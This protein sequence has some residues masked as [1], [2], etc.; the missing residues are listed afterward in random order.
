M[1]N[2]NQISNLLTRMVTPKERHRYLLEPSNAFGAQD[3][4]IRMKEAL[5]WLADRVDAL[6]KGQVH[7]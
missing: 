7:E 4:V 3:D 6:E 5:L 1:K 2:R